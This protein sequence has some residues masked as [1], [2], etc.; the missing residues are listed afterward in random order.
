MINFSHTLAVT[1]VLS[2][3]ADTSHAQPIVSP[4]FSV[5]QRQN[6]PAREQSIN[7]VQVPIFANSYSQ[8]LNPEEKVTV[9]INT[10]FLTVCSV[11]RITVTSSD[12]TVISIQKNPL[13]FTLTAHHT[14]IGE[15]KTAIL[16][17]QCGRYSDSIIIRM[18]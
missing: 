16:S 15:N 1:A 17:A 10:D 7:P 8:L 12:P 18:R 2:I 6:L 5:Y 11:D 4:S 9:T 14:G 13:N 3:C